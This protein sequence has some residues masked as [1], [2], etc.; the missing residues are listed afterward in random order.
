MGAG[1]VRARGT[2]SVSYKDA[3]HVRLASGGARI[4]T[5][6]TNCFSRALTVKSG[7]RP[8]EPGTELCRIGDAD[9]ETYISNVD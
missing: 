9:T 6:G 7:T 2:H 4:D 5:H 8:G 1:F 3:G